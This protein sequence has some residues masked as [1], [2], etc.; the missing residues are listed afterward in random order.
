[1][2]SKEKQNMEQILSFKRTFYDINN[3]DALDSEIID[4]LKDK[5]EMQMLVKTMEQVKKISEN[6]SIPQKNNVENMV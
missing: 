3:R 1:M 4:N 2:V 5:I 6:M